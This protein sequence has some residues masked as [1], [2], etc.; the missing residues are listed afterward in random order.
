M[1]RYIDTD[2][3]KSDI[4][5]IA[6]ITGGKLTEFEVLGIL[7]GQ[8]IADVVE[9]VRCKDCKYYKEDVWAEVNNVPLIV[10]H[11][12]CEFWGD[13]CKTEENSYCS[14]GEREC[15]EDTDES[16]I[17]EWICLGHRSG[18]LKHP[19]SVDYKCSNCGHEEYTL[20]SPPPERC[21]N[22]RANMKGKEDGM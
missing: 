14:Y 3:L 6:K 7:S 19:Y 2:K 20:L 13:G 10:A 1:R 9:V 4:K 21:P 15:E 17:A 8:P 11:E 12:M 16:V 18:Y 22:C 5:E